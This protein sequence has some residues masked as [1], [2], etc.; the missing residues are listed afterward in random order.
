MKRGF[1]LV[2]LLVVIAIIGLLASVTLASLE[3]ARTKARD[4]K[5]LADLRQITIALNL[6]YDDNGR[7]PTEGAPDNANGRIAAGG[8][9]NINTILANYMGTAPTDPIN[10]GTHYYYY[11]G[12]Q[13]CGGE[14]DLVPVL[15]IRTLEVLPSNRT[16]LCNGSWG[17]EGGIG[18]VGSY[19][20]R[21]G[22]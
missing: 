20:E 19:M 5:R 12:A 13:S 18:G 11:D 9:A 21:L 15:A 17:G 6:F 22:R 14:P 3:S 10:D 1:T 7:Y 16:E 8:G 4:T 2:E